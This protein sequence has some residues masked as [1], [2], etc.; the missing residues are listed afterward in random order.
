MVARPLRVA[1]G[2]GLSHTRG[3]GLDAWVYRVGF[4]VAVKLTRRL[5]LAAGHE[6]SLQRGGPGALAGED[7]VHNAV[8]IRVVSG[9]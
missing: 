8:S 9:N 7:I 5:S 1:I 3:L 6:L 2:P 4:D